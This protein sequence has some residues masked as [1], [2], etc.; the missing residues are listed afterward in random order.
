MLWNFVLN[1]R[2]SFSYARRGAVGT[3]L[4]RYVAVSA[5][6]ALAS[7][8]TTSL[9]WNAFRVKQAAATLGVLAGTGFNFA[10]SRFLVFRMRRGG[11]LGARLGDA[12]P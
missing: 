3:Q 9:L 7:Y 12:V 1:R 4:A 8:A 11:A 6:G 10:G 5:V 2:F